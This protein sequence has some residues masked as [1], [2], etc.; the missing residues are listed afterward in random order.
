MR[1]LEVRRRVVGEGHRQVGRV[2]DVEQHRLDERGPAGEE[3]VL[4][5]GAAPAGPQD[6]PAAAGDP[7]A[8]DDDGVGAR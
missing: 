1:R 6:H 2:V 5:V 8:G 4:R 7:V 3:H